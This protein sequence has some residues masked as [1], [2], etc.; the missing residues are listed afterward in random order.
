MQVYIMKYVHS[1]NPFQNIEFTNMFKLEEVDVV[2]FDDLLGEIS[3][4]SRDHDRFVGV[5][6]M[7]VSPSSRARY[8]DDVGV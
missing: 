2:R 5:D 8:R 6:G 4:G 7:S 1:Q 3:G